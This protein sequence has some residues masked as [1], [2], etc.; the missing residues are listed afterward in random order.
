VHHLI[1]F[2]RD[3]LTIPKIKDLVNTPTQKYENM[4]LAMNQNKSGS[5]F[6]ETYKK[7]L[8]PQTFQSSQIDENEVLSMK[9]ELKSYLKSQQLESTSSSID[10]L[11]S[12][13]NLS[14]YTSS[15]FMKKKVKITELM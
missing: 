9:N 6:D 2:F 8:L 4:F 14:Q 7:S 3:T 10:E 1:Q 12:L 5:S 15:P 13:S 11:N